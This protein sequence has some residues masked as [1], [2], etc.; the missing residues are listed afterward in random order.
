MVKVKKYEHELYRVDA[1]YS[2]S[3]FKGIKRVSELTLYECRDEV[4]H[5]MDVIEKIRGKGHQIEDIIE[6]AGF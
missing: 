2:R 1:Q 6:K 4:C 3:G 5:L